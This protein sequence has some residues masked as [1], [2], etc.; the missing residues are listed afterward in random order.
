LHFEN[1]SQ[2]SAGS[3][4]EGVV[5]SNEEE[6]GS[7]FGLVKLYS[8]VGNSVV[9]WKEETSKGLGGKFELR[10]RSNNFG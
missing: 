2:T 5:D 3:I 7:S 6:E 8:Q 9:E 10:A 4:L 1:S